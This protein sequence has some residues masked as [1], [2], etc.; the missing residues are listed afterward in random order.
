MPRTVVIS[1]GSR[2]LGAVLTKAF[3]AED[4]Y[5]VAI[6]S[7][8]RTEFIDSVLAEE[9]LKS[10]FLFKQVDLS[11]RAA[12]HEYVREVRERFGS[13]HVL[14]NNAG[15]AVDGVLALQ[16]DTAVDQ[17]VDINLKGSVALTKACVREMLINRWGRIVTITSIVGKSGFRGLSVYSM[18]KAGLDGF[19]R[20]L[21]RELGDRGITVNSVAPGFL[22][23]EMTHGLSPEQKDQILRRTPAGRLGRSEDVA[24]VVKFLCS[25]AAAFVTGQTIIVDGGAMA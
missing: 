4:D 18:T 1:G 10:R 19:T 3:L 14:V 13:V 23:T 17:M 21:A 16:T 6:C 5:N 25:D 12:V 8:S 9:R 22:E 24:G 11:D 2:G 20:S 7:R 15:V